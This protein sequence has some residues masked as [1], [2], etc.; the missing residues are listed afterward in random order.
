MPHTYAHSNR[1]TLRPLAA[2]PAVGFPLP[3]AGPAT[4]ANVSLGSW[5]ELWMDDQIEPCRA[6]TTVNGY[7]N[8]IRNH[9]RPALAGCGWPT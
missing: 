4:N 5:L 8:I 6:E 1:I 9:L 7:R 2:S 3:H